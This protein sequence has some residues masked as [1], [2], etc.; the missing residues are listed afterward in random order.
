MSRSRIKDFHQLEK[1]FID[2]PGSDVYATLCKS[3]QNCKTLLFHSRHFIVCL[4]NVVSKWVHTE[5][6]KGGS[7]QLKKTSTEA[8][9][10]IKNENICFVLL[11]N[12]TLTLS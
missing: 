2:M 7:I 9:Q 8:L 10:T 12:I 5:M 4:V 1:G 3:H 6:R 11:W